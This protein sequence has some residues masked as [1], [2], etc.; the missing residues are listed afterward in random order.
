MRP[1]Q[2]ASEYQLE[3]EILDL[4]GRA[5]MRPRQIASEYACQTTG[6]SQLLELQ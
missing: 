6:Q 5:S 1:R 4:E 3:D 2:I